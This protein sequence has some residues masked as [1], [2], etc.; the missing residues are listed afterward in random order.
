MAAACLK[1]PERVDETSLHERRESRAFLG[2]EAV[3]LHIVLRTGEIDLG[4]RDVQVAAEDD[5]LLLFQTLEVGEKI[6]VPRLAIR[7]AREFALR[8]RDIDVH[9]KEIIE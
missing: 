4:V 6:A 2:G 9:K 5:G 8:I 1:L 7:Q 3:V